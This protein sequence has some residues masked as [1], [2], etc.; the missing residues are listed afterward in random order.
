MVWAMP[1]TKS[2]PSLSLKVLEE[3]HVNLC[4]PK[5]FYFGAAW[6]GEQQ[7]AVVCNDLATVASPV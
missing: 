5:D 6:P 2:P 4:C 3:A 1:S 7:F